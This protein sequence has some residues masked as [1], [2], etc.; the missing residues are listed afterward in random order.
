MGRKSIREEDL[1][2]LNGKVVLVTGGNTGIGY[3]TV[4]MLARRGARVYMGARNGVRAAEA[5][6]RLKAENM[7]DGSVHWLELDLSDSRLASQAAKE[8][9]QREDRLDILINNAGVQPNE[10]PFKLTAD[11]LLDIMVINHISPF[12][13]TEALLPLMKRTAAEPGSDVRIVNVTSYRHTDVAPETLAS[14]EALNLNLG[15]ST[16]DKVYTYGH[17]KLANILH[18]KALQTRLT[19]E[20]VCITC[21]APHPGIIA[22]LGSHRAMESAPLGWFLTRVIAPLFFK[23][24]REGAMP[25]VFAAAGP[26]VIGPEHAKYKGAYLTPMDVVATPSKSAQDPRLQKELYETTERIVRELGL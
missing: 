1:V 22:T 6:E 7:G 11:G 15:D 23:S 24:S 18:I 14:K 8:F 12:V 26:E 20:G 13:L 16:M 2:D 17:T 5:I 19:A 4:Q 10:H 3:A 9:L 25:V 21:L